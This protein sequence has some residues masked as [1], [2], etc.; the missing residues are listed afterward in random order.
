MSSEDSKSALSI[1]IRLLDSSLYALCLT[2]FLLLSSPITLTVQLLLSMVTLLRSVRV[3]GISP[4]LC[5]WY[6]NS[7]EPL[8]SLVSL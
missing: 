6:F 8:G 2:R 7:P 4:Q 5:I 3:F 1:R